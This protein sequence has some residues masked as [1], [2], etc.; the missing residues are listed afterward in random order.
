MSAS[1]T[2]DDGPIREF[3]I[4]ENIDGYLQRRGHKA[5]DVCFTE[6]G[7][8]WSL[9]DFCIPEECYLTPGLNPNVPQH[10]PIGPEPPPSY[11]LPPPARPQM[12]RCRAKAA[13]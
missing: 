11:P 2:L 7:A 5:K 1:A 12:H 10:G 6:N 8:G 9:Q 4:A 13:R 3:D